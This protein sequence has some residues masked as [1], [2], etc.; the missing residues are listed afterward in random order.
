MIL[1]KAK[2]KGHVHSDIFIALQNQTCVLTEFT[3][4]MMAPVITYCMM[5]TSL[6]I[7]MPHT[8]ITRPYL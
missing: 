7:G 8:S 1:D 3:K 2:T 4:S 6:H 5:A